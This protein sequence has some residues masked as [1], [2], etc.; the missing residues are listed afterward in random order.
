MPEN[1]QPDERTAIKNL[2]KILL[3]T[4]VAALPFLLIA[5]PRG[6]TGTPAGVALP[7]AGVMLLIAW[8]IVREVRRYRRVPAMREQA[9]RQIIMLLIYAMLLSDLFH[10]QWRRLAE[11]DTE[12]HGITAGSFVFAQQQI[13]SERCSPP[14]ASNWRATSSS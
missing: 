11:P 4:A 2:R 9:V 13:Q 12:P 3:I 7:A 8:G 10:L 1:H 14:S 5:M 6:L